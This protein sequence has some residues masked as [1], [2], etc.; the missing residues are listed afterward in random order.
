MRCVTQAI[1]REATVAG[2]EARRIRL[3]S[4]TRHFTF[5]EAAMIRSFRHRGLKLLYEKGSRKGIPSQRAEQIENVL[6]VL[7]VAS[8]IREIHFQ[9]CIP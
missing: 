5:L 7:D 3:T 1:T 2:R 4:D 8:S 6:S 9:E